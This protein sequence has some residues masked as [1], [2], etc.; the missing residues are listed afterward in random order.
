MQHKTFYV[1]SVLLL[2]AGCVTPPPAVTYPAT[3]QRPGTTATPPPVAVPATA[4]VPVAP[5]APVTPAAPA[6]D[7]AANDRAIL[8]A[9]R[10]YD[11][12]DFNSAVRQMNVIINEGALD[13]A[14]MVR[15]LK[16]LAFSQCSTNAVTSCRQ[17]FERLL[18]IDPS[19]DLTA[20]E[21]G[22][23]IW[24][25]QFAQARRAALGK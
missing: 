8:A 21:R 7:T 20:T 5:P 24:G 2:L 1:L 15:A 10:S 14:Q 3:A 11:R 23:P 25:P 9:T 12:G 17:S 4:Q 22:H 19:F 18:K 13:S 16:V 6:V